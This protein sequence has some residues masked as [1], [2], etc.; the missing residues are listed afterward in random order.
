MSV[1]VGLIVASLFAASCSNSVTKLDEEIFYAGPSFSLKLVRY[2]ENLPLHYTG[3]IFVVSCAS[4]ATSRS[5][6]QHTQ[7]AGW[8]QVGRG[9]AIGSTSAHDV[10]Q[11]ERS[12][13]IVLRDRVLFVPGT[14]MRVSFNFCAGFEQWDP[15]TL[16]PD[17]LTSRERPEFCKPKGLGDCRYYDFEGDW[18]P[19]YTDIELGE[20]GTLSF[21]VSAKAFKSGTPLIVKTSDSGRTWSVDPG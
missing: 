12:K 19:H 14:V 1:M 11:R 5:Q 15:T 10:V 18:V 3:D 16:P 2:H 17:S 9:G 21:R 6:A 4:K 8:V 13:Y 7:D 20:G